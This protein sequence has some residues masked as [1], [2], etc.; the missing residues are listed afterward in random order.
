MVKKYFSP[1]TDILSEFNTRLNIIILDREVF[2]NVTI[3]K[4]ECKTLNNFS[5]GKKMVPDF[6]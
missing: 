2:K 3:Y 6:F 4:E 1:T 5:K